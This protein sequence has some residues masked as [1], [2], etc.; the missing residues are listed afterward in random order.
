MLFICSF[1][2]I[3]GGDPENMTNSQESSGETLGEESHLNSQTNEHC[4]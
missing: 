3:S 1:F 2:H 4:K